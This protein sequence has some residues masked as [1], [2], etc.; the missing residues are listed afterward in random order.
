M[1][2]P[3]ALAKAAE[4]HKMLLE[5]EKL[6]NPSV[7]GE[8]EEEEEDEEEEGEVD[9]NEEFSSGEEE[10]NVS[11]HKSCQYNCSLFT[12]SHHLSMHT[13]LVIKGLRPGKRR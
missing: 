6:K 10:N 7:E 2:T 9:D 3:E 8:E 4:L 13:M 5:E 1:E 11:S 12:H